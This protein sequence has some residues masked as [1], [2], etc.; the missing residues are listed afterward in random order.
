MAL[1]QSLACY[2]VWPVSYPCGQ[3]RSTHDEAAL[4]GMFGVTMGAKDMIPFGSAIAGA[5]SKRL[6]RFGALV[7]L[8]TNFKAHP[9]HTRCH[10]A[11]AETLLRLVDA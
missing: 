10:R 1:P 3:V 5:H 7:I 9:E 11:Y 4:C 8:R 2:L 6:G